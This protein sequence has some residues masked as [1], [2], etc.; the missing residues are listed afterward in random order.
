MT[1]VAKL[2]DTAR[3][4]E[5]KGQWKEALD[6]YER[7]VAATE[8]DEFDVGALNRIGDLHLRL[9]QPEAAVAAYDRA[10][11]AYVDVGLYNNA[12]ALCKKILRS[13]P[14][15]NEVY[16]RLGQIS[17][18][19]GF[20]ADAKNNFLQYAT[21]MKREGKLDASFQALEEFADL[22][23]GD[24]EV[25][26]LLAEQLESHDRT[27]KAVVQ[28]RLLFSQLR[29]LGKAAEAEEVREKILELDPDAEVS[30]GA[31]TDAD[32]EAGPVMEVEGFA[33]VLGGM[34]EP[35]ATGA[36]LSGLQTNEDFSRLDSV[37][38][39]DDLEDDD[40][41]GAKLPLLE[42]LPGGGDFDED[43]EEGAGLPLPTLEPSDAATDFDSGLVEIRPTTGEPGLDEEEDEYGAEPLPMLGFDDQFSAPEEIPAAR[44]APRAAAPTDG[45]LPELLRRV[46]AAPD[47]RDARERAVALLVRGGEEDEARLLLE[48][49]HRALATDGRYVEASD[50]VHELIGVRPEDTP[51]YQKQV[52]Y[53]FR[54]GDRSRLIRAYLD[55]AG[56]L[57]VL[58]NAQKA[59][60]VYQRV[61]DLDPAN[62]DARRFAGPSAAEAPP[63]SP[64]APAAPRPAATDDGYVDLGALIL[65]EEESGEKTTRFV[66]RDEEPT[67]DEDADFADML[68]R[69]KNKVAENIDAEDS[70]SHY[71]LGLAFKDMGLIDE[72]ISQFQ[73]ALRGGANPLATL[74]VLGECFVEKGQYTLAGRVLERAL[75]LD[76]KDTELIGVYY[77]LGRCKEVLGQPDVARDYFERVLAL[78][79]RFRDAAG[80]IEAIRA[81]TGG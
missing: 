38:A 12:I 31:E 51:P 8:G 27:E 13:V 53:A 35:S 11:T 14:D 2:K 9:G 41:A 30:D 79:I 21:A 59:E 55:L 7:V 49:A 56:H 71:D 62:D 72:A 69:F 4:L 25:R 34:D 42:I 1:N 20:V 67:G 78:D 6:A 28:L 66:V 48:D 45:D 39:E 36:E 50:V 77:L 46:R 26:R 73:V 33:D 37:S 32:G 19:Q 74:E 52:E 76:A 61:L 81:A 29:A 60:A 5:Q 16:L 75:Q 64:A 65:D 15:R 18:T 23:P 17:A 54:A 40:E 3:T 44:R 58:G 57:R 47:D 10:V 80:R 70:T 63:A 43:D 24:V 68:S 22:S